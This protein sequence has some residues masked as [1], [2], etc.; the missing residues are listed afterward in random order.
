APT[1][2]APAATPAPTPTP[3]PAA[4]APAPTTPAPAATP[5]PTPT[6]APAADAPAPT[7]PAPAANSAPAPTP[8]PA[9]AADAPAPATSAPAATPAP[10]PTPT[11]GADVPATT[12]PTPAATPGSAPQPAGRELY[13]RAKEE[14]RGGDWVSAR[15]DF[16]A[17]IDAGYSQKPSL[18]EDSAGSYLEKMDKKESSDRT[19]GAA[20]AGG[21]PTPGAVAAVTPAAP[22]DAAADAALNVTA[23]AEDL[24]H[25]QAV[26]QSDILVRQARELQA[27]N[28]LDE[29]RDKYAE[30]VR[31][32]PNNASAQAGLDQILTL[33]GRSTRSPNLIAEQQAINN[34]RI[35]AIKYSF[36]KAIAEARQAT[37]DHQFGLA[38]TALQ[39]AQYAAGSD[40][41]I[42]PQ[43]DLRGFDQQIAAARL[44]L[45]REMERTRFNA[46]RDRQVNA[47]RQIDEDRKRAALER[48]RTVA[49]LQRTAIEHTKA[50]RYREALGVVD[51]ILVLDPNDAYALG[52]RPMLEDKWQFQVQRIHNELQDRQFTNQ[53]NAA[54]ERLIPYDDILRYPT[55]WP[56]ISATRD[57]TVQQERGDS[58]DD[59]AVQAQLDRALPEVTFDGVGFSDVVDFLRDVSGANI[60][61]NWKSLEA[62]AVDKNA[63]VSA[64]LR[65]VKFSKALA[66]ILDSVGGGTAKLGYTIDEG[67]IT[68]S[69][70]DDL[71][72]NTITR[73][74]DI[75]DLI[76]NI[77]DFTDAP[78]F[79]LNTTSNNQSQNPGQQGGAGAGGG[80]GGGGGNLFSGGTGQ[81]KAGPTRDE[82]I[83][84]IT[85]L[86][87]DTVSPESWRDS[88]GTVGSI[89]E[90]QGQL[91]VTQTP[92]NQHAL[93][94]LLEQLRETRAIQVTIETRFLTVQRNF[95]EDVGVN[96]SMIFNLNSAMNKNFS[97]IAINNSSSNYTM[98]PTTSVPGSLGKTVTSLTTSATYLDD[99]QVSL[100]LRATE[101]TQKS[102][103]VQ[104]PRVTLFNG[105]RAYVLVAIQQAYVSNLTA[106]VGTG[107]SSFTPIVSIV[108]SGVLL[109]VSATVSAD[110]KYVTLTLRPQLSTLLDLASFTFQNGTNTA[111][112]G[113]GTGTGAG[114][115]F[116]VVGG[117][118]SPSG[119]IQEPELQITEVKTTVSVP[120]GGTLLLG[121]QSIAGETEREA[122]VPILSKVPF[123]KRLF[124]NHS[125][126]KDEQVLLILVKPT[127]IIEKEIEQKQ[128]P[129]LTSKL[130]G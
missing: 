5:A 39:R 92:E 115:G 43:S 114:F 28:R 44:D 1:T 22:A 7:T 26:S 122:G 2:P 15:K 87:T 104:A 97:P 24:Q 102:S 128:F 81:E 75:R 77:P 37:Q 72:K 55:D 101:A 32:N 41:A 119:T 10:A 35:G 107:V 45:D 46:E 61:V 108:E 13:L 127:I 95:V 27:A 71:A 57:Q 73:V 129:L 109:D 111:G 84:K 67:V 12:T 40:R 59:R 86:I 94:N 48:A 103:F 85:K 100:L 53:M 74:Y 63:P 76:I 19:V 113:V 105:Q 18:W 120:D 89:R 60:F 16:K 88:G 54:D 14:Y 110:R 126:A 130:G 33:Q 116:G 99:F 9:P 51:Q 11:P 121:G 47:V 34:E 6:P 80:G 123:L 91:I 17:A 4:D 69:T 25:Q 68:I 82:L 31:V 118:S 62:A 49:D 20:P 125:M 36:D 78:D 106:A 23:R 112:G 30:A 64:K 65:N 56:D 3:A 124:T 21:A 96:L 93:V 117:F 50:T 90:L 29:A 58:K 79:S 42:F 83:E 66:V 70:T 8:T 38:E 98:G 52:V